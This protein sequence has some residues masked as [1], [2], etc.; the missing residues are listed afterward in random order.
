MSSECRSA[1]ASRNL[2]TN[3]VPP[4]IH[5]RFLCAVIIPLYE[6]VRGDKSPQ[7]SFASIRGAKSAYELP[8]PQ[9]HDVIMFFAAAWDADQTAVNEDAMKSIERY[10][11]AA[12]RGHGLDDD[13][14]SDDLNGRFGSLGTI[15]VSR[16]ISTFG[17]TF[18]VEIA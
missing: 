10:V 17:I 15:T 11:G 8:T 16:R 18:S 13:E 7:Y 5:W 12:S 3:P 2:S 14:I 4:R 1:G 9:Q 6:P